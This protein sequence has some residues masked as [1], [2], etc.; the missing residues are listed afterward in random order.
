[1]LH[2]GDSPPCPDV[3]VS[4][5]I[6][7]GQ[8]ARQGFADTTVPDTLRRLAAMAAEW[9][10]GTR[11]ATVSTTVDESWVTA[12]S[13]SPLAT[14]VDA[15]QYE[16][17]SGP[18]L[19]AITSGS[20]CYTTDLRKDTR[21]PVLARRVREEGLGA[22]SVLSAPISARASEGRSSLNIYSDRPHAF[23]GTA[24]TVAMILSVY[25]GLLIDA[26]VNRHEASRLRRTLAGSDHPPAAA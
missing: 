13:T 15:V 20:A 19:Q 5:A 17:R 12:A 10:P 11:W 22:A 1:M 18:C 24:F 8:E 25:A 21:W 16:T 6:F 4:L 9:V 2:E 23:D 7:L 14:G 26:T 3:L